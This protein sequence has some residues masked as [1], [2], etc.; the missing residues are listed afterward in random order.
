MVGP[1]ERAS[2]RLDQV[3]DESRR[4]GEVIPKIARGERGPAGAPG[5]VRGWRVLRAE[6]GG[7]LG[8]SQLHAQS[9]SGQRLLVQ[10]GSIY[11]DR[12]CPTGHSVATRQCP[13]ARPPL[14]AG[15]GTTAP[16]AAR[17]GR[18]RHLGPCGGAA[19]AAGRAALALWA[20]AAVAA[21]LCRL[22]PALAAGERRHGG[23]GPRNGAGRAAPPAQHP[24]GW[25]ARPSRC[26]FPA[27]PSRRSFCWRADRTLWLFLPVCFRCQVE[28]DN[29]AN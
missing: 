7:Y 29:W 22:Q 13:H 6:L 27:S 25:K 18:R 28:S 15:A 3:L 26:P 4:S 9:P 12:Q 8:L 1:G 21:A 17:G 2:Y 23:T 19:M 24:A 5:A 20:V 16:M 14:S 11:R 10:H